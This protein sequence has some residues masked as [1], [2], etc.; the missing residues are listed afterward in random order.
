M[1]VAEQAEPAHFSVGCAPKTLPVSHASAERVCR[2]HFDPFG[3]GKQP[4]C[5]PVPRNSGP[6]HAPLSPQRL[7]GRPAGHV[8][9]RD[10]LPRPHSFRLDDHR[11]PDPF[12]PL[13][14]AALRGCQPSHRAAA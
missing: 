14:A 9:Q 5:A 6:I 13:S 12:R 10:L 8:R 3:P 11:E 7:A 2:T 1:F 4:I